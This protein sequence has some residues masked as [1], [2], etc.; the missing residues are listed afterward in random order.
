MRQ[1]DINRVNKAKSHLL[2]AKTL[3]SNIKWENINQLEAELRK[4]ALEEII[5]ADYLLM[6]ILNI[7]DF[8]K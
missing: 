7:Q 2:A 3:L 4:H 8:Q 5:G 6:D 1:A